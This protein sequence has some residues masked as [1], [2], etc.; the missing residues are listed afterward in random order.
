MGNQ[1]E[2]TASLK[3]NTIVDQAIKDLNNFGDALNNAWKSSEPPKQLQKSY[4]NLETYLGSLT[5]L[6]KKLTEENRKA[7]GTE[8]KQA[9]SDYAA[10]QKTIH[11]LTVEFGLMS[12]E[13]KRAMLSTEEQANMKARA[14]AIKEYTA[15]LTKNN[16]VRAKRKPLE[17]ERAQL[18][19]EQA[20][21]RAK[22]QATLDVS[23]PVLEAL[24]KRGYL[25]SKEG[26]AYR[27]NLEWAKKYQTELDKLQSK[28]N[29]TEKDNK[30]I[31]KK[32]EDIAALNVQI[33]LMY[34]LLVPS[35]L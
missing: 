26:E 31:A 17:D 1:K 5:A 6:S 35:E 10:I 15:A 2:L 34:V 23:K 27:N 7:T 13:Q 21:K 32:K 3:I 25:L 18:V 11:S 4:K 33:V 19:Q 22:A 12:A 30:A 14:A 20:P 16:E 24:E 29:K 28:P 9:A 8:L